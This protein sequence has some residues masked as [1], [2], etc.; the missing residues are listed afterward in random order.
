ME[1]A[2][3]HVRC[4]GTGSEQESLR[5]EALKALL[6]TSVLPVVDNL[7]RGLKALESQGNSTPIQAALRTLATKTNG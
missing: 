3:L 4:H 7:N 2:L 1:A 6:L 5:R